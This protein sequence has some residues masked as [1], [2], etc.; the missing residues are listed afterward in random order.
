MNKKQLIQELQE[1]LDGLFSPIVPKKPDN[2]RKGGFV[3]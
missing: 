3:K 1:L 2:I